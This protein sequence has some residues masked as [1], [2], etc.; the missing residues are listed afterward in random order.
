MSRPPRTHTL[1]AELA[2]YRSQLDAA[3]RQRWGVKGVVYR[4]LDKLYNMFIMAVVVYL[5]GVEGL[6]PIAGAALGVVFAA[7][8][9]GGEELLLSRTDALATLLSGRRPSDDSDSDDDNRP[10]RQG[11]DD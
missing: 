4:A 7:V 10:P 2:A 1:T 6:E 8:S 3:T 5:V 9:Y 11:S